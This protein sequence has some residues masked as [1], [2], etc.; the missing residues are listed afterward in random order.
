MTLY[1]IFDRYIIQS[2]LVLGVFGNIFMLV[3]I[4]Q[5]FY[6][7]YCKRYWKNKLCFCINDASISGTPN[8]DTP[9]TSA[10]TLQMSIY[11]FFLAVSDIGFLISAFFSQESFKQKLGNCHDNNIGQALVNAFKGVSDVIV[12]FMTYHRLHSIWNIQTHNSDA[13]S[14]RR[15]KQKMW[16]N[17]YWILIQILLA[18]ITGFFFHIPFFIDYNSENGA[19][20][21]YELSSK[22]EYYISS[23]EDK[24]WQTSQNCSIF[25]WIH[26]TALKIIPTFLIVAFNIAIAWKLWEVWKKR[27][28]IR[29]N[30]IKGLEIRIRV[31]ASPRNKIKQQDNNYLSD[32]QNH[33]QVPISSE[34]NSTVTHF[35]TSTP[36]IA[37]TSSIMQNLDTEITHAVKTDKIKNCGAWQSS[38]AIAVPM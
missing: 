28:S 26:I 14:F 27:Q 10:V 21:F 2:L 24:D 5:L 1:D 13:I 8:E 6:G 25:L 15:I 12:T 16:T 31:D 19:C 23:S 7:G 18:F 22:S 33:L 9:T 20:D 4:L 17:N 36:S 37:E 38:F 30:A 11:L 3:I 29:K 35:Q 32:Q 34:E